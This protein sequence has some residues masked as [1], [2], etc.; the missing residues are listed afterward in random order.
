[1]ETEQSDQWKHIVVNFECDN[2]DAAEEILKAIIA[3]LASY[4]AVKN[5]EAFFATAEPALD[6]N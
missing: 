5:F 4:H 2:D 1:M 6:A 3:I